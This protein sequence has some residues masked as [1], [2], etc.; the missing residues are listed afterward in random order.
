MHAGAVTGKPK[1]NPEEPQ[2]A[3]RVVEP[4]KAR[5][6][7]EEERPPKIPYY[8]LARNNVLKRTF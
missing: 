3:G 8:W 1:L 7:E 6:E 5:A 2:E 4:K